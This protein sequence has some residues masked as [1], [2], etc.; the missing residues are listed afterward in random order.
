MFNLLCLQSSAGGSIQINIHNHRLAIENSGQPGH[1]ADC[2][3]VCS[4]SK[5]GHASGATLRATW[6]VHRSKW[7]KHLGLERAE[8]FDNHRCNMLKFYIY[9]YLSLGLI[10]HGQRQA[11]NFACPKHTHLRG[12]ESLHMPATAGV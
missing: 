9:I 7:I 4:A 2:R 12:N 6:A 5:Q 10:P 11:L 3:G 8:A 1:H